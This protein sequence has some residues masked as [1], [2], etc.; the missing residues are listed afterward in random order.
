LPE[1]NLHS[2]SFGK[3]RNFKIQKSSDFEVF[4]SPEVSKSFLV[5]IAK[6]IALGFQCVAKI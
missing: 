4:Q 3:I 2:F 5:K 1:T 6:I